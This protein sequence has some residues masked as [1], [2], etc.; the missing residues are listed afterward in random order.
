[1]LTAYRAKPLERA[2]KHTQGEQGQRCFDPTAPVQVLL[3]VHMTG[4]A[5][6]SKSLESNPAE[7][8]GIVTT[9]LEYLK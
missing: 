6:T 4:G 1:M 5:E 3:P 7:N 9:V 2:I 8:R